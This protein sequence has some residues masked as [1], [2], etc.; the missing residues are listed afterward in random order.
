MHI[1]HATAVSDELVAAM[2]RLIPQLSPTTRIPTPDDLAA[3]VAQPSTFLLLARDPDIVGTLTLTLF[4]VP[5]G[6][7]GLISNVVVDAGARGRGV[8]EALT[9]EAMRRSRAVG[10][11]RLALNSRNQREAANRLYRRLGFVAVATNAYRL[12][13]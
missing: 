7:Q 12:T 11:Y 5:T 1:E 9:R 4:R 6:V 10:A 8:G 13:P 2:A 3:V